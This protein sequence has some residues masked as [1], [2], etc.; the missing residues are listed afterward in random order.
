M[1]EGLK[2]EK[3]NGKG[4]GKALFWDNPPMAMCGSYTFKLSSSQYI[5]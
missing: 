1:K 5:R 2:K 4:K 3:K